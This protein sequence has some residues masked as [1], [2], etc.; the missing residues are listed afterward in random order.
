MTRQY[1]FRVEVDGYLNSGGDAWVENMIKLKIDE[2]IKPRNLD[3][4][5][6]RIVSIEKLRPLRAERYAVFN[7][8]VEGEEIGRFHGKP[9][10]RAVRKYR[11]PA[12]ARGYV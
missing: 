4:K 10:A 5:K 3:P 7:V 9:Y 2:L 11:R 12:H 8:T 6:T 1:V